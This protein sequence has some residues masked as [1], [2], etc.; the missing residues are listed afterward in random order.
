MTG[1]RTE[2]MWKGL[3]GSRARALMGDRTAER[4]AVFFAP[5]LRS[6]MRL[7]DCGCGP[8][9]ITLG[10]AAIVAPAEAV[11]IDIGEGPLRMAR[12]LA[13]E[14]GITNVRFQTANVSELLFPDRSFD[15][16][17]AHAV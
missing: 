9:S 5:H 1:F 13:S 6:G 17:F 3:K 10:L 16:V 15:A 8:G 2:A 7:L 4:Q 14:L 11:G 12:E